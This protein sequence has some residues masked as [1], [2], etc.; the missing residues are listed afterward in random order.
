MVKFFGKI[1]KIFEKI[2]NF[3]RKVRKVRFL[4]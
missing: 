3:F 2:G 4:R 1:G